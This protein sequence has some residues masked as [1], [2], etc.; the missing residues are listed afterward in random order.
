MVYARAYNR[1]WISR[2]TH[3]RT[4]WERIAVPDLACGR[5]TAPNSDQC[6]DRRVPRLIDH[7]SQRDAVTAAMADLI[8]EGGLAAA[9]LRGI[10]RHSRVS[11]A[12]LTECWGGRDRM[13]RIATAHWARAWQ[14]ALWR[15]FDSAGLLGLLP[16]DDE[17]RDQAR[18]WL[19]LCE[20]A[21]CN[22]QVRHSVEE[23]RV[24]ERRM[25]AIMTDRAWPE[26]EVD[27]LAAVI[28]GLRHALCTPGCEVAVDRAARTLES[29]L[30]RRRTLAP[31]LRERGRRSVGA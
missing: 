10:A 29:F 7:F 20:L 12:A 9:S 21:R 28:D 11:S 14:A 15:R 24:E 2:C 25:L 30:D 18:V 27:L 8:V 23:A 13:L 16:R 6:W 19:A 31:D 1:G 3:V 17:E 4:S 26:T 5:K 22:E